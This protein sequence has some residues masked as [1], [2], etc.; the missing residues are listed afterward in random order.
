MPITRDSR[1]KFKTGLSPRVGRMNKHMQTATLTAGFLQCRKVGF[2]I[3]FEMYGRVNC[4]GIKLHLCICKEFLIC[5]SKNMQYM[6]FR[7]ASGKAVKGVG[8][9]CCL[10]N[11]AWME[12]TFPW[13]KAKRTGDGRQRSPI[14]H[15]NSIT[16]P[17]AWPSCSLLPIQAEVMTHDLGTGPRGAGLWLILRPTYLQLLCPSLMPIT[18]T[19]LYRFRSECQQILSY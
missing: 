1:S 19:A 16:V 14:S 17:A 4:S 2:S 15:E 8:G 13:K 9:I 3:S 6:R 18:Q 5:N 10:P 7:Y 12:N 11:T